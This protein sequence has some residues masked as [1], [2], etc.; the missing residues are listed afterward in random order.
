[1]N[2]KHENVVEWTRVLEDGKF[3]ITVEG[4]PRSGT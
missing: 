3:E 2:K 4:S 1:M